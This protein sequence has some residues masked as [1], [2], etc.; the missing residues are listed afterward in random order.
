MLLLEK[1]LPFVSFQR[2][3]ISISLFQAGRYGCLFSCYLVEWQRVC[4]ISCCWRPGPMKGSKKKRKGWVFLR[5]A[6]AAVH[7]SP[8]LLSEKPVTSLMINA[9]AHR[10][11]SKPRQTL[12]P[13]NLWD[14]PPTPPHSPG[15]S[16]SACPPARRISGSRSLPR[17]VA[18]LAECCKQKSLLGYRRGN[19]H[20]HWQVK[21]QRRPWHHRRGNIWSWIVGGIWLGDGN[22]M[23]QGR[24]RGA[25]IAISV[26]T[27][28][29]HGVISNGVTRP[30]V[31]FT[32]VP[33]GSA[34]ADC[35]NTNNSS[36]VLLHLGPL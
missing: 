12:N 8:D 5:A 24:Y 11:V 13:D 28:S 29:H 36:S 32:S 33:C 2:P 25:A 30:F 9:P 4:L 34:P 16:T 35:F 21:P 14:Y 31:Y 20:V 23:C 10:A 18:A 26:W 1:N 3:S 19:A 15:P 6:M 27:N 22:R 17:S 7:F